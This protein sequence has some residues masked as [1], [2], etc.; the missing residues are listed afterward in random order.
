M[1]TVDKWFAKILHENNIR[2][3]TFASYKQIYIEVDLISLYLY[4]IMVFYKIANDF[5]YKQGIVTISTI[6]C[7]LAYT[8]FYFKISFNSS[9]NVFATRDIATIVINFLE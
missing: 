6:N 3:K 9:P 1:V 8:L 7:Q 5:V 2:N 4:T